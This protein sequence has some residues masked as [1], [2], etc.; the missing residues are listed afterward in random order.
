MLEK[1]INLSNKII[2]NRKLSFEIKMSVIIG[3]CN[4]KVTFLKKILRPKKDK[5]RE[6]ERERENIFVN[7]SFVYYSFI[8]GSK[9]KLD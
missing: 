2:Q 1:K 8:C 6:R 4:H 3:P 9:W 5:Q 7:V